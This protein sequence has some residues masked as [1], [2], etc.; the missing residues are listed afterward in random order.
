MELVHPVQIEGINKQELDKYIFFKIFD[1][2]E[3]RSIIDKIN[4]FLG[5]LK[6]IVL[7]TGLYHK[8]K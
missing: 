3:N 2:V 7:T 5:I 8:E 1:D 6:Y 4:I